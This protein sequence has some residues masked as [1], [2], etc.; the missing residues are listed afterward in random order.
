MGQLSGGLKDTIPP[1][2]LQSEPQNYSVNFKG[3]K[4]EI[5][6]NEFITLDNINQQLVVSPPVENRVDV[7]LKNKTILIDLNN[8]LQDSTTYTLNFGDAIK[9]N[10]EGNLLNNFEYVFSTGNYLDSLSVYGRLVNSFDLKPSE[11]PVSILLYDDLSDSAFL[12]HGPLYV[13]KTGK[14]GYFAMNNLRSDTFHIFALKDLNSNFYFDLPNEEIAFLDTSLIS[15]TR[16]FH[17][18]DT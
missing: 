9:D 4:I 13:S 11:D 16:I 10:N 6:F 1:V 7:R 14:E 3:Q 12:K 17:T 8:E 18:G 5:T 15:Y 2:V